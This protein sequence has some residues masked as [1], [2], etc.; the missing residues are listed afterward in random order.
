MLQ[1]FSSVILSAAVIALLTLGIVEK[2]NGR[3]IVSRKF[4][5]SALVCAALLIGICTFSV[6]PAGSTGVLVT[7]GSP[8]NQGMRAGPH[9]KIPFAQK[10]VVIDNRVQRTDVNGSGASRDLQTI[11]TSVSVNYRVNPAQSAA[12]YK[13]VGT[14][15]ETVIVRPA[16]QECMKAVQSQ[17]T[18]EELI[19]RR[20]E[21]GQA[22]QESIAEK[23]GRYGLTVDNI[24]ILNMDFSEEFNAAI[25]A[26]QTAQQNALKA[27][28]DLARIEVEAKQKIVTAQA[29]ADAN[30]IRSESITNEILISNAISRWD[31][32]LPAV[33]GSDGN[34]FDIS[35][36]I[37]K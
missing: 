33:I 9:F 8:S 1:I 13:E 34:I 6:V 30:R 32:K 31:G 25:E 21:V 23:V 5:A 3:T 2:V 29:E 27:E 24:N 17:Y 10:I 20:S 22:M 11:N 14:D 4:F 12:I 15:W 28:Q 19:T 26:K 35:S 16:V 36:A 18:A 37:G 7:L